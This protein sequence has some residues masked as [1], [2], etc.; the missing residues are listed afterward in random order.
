MDQCIY[1]LIYMQIRD[2]PGRL[3]TRIDAVSCGTRSW[4]PMC[5]KGI[6][7]E[8][9]GFEPAIPLR[10]CRIS[11]AVLSTTQPP[12]RCHFIEWFIAFVSRR[13]IV[14]D[15]QGDNRSLGT[16]SCEPIAVWLQI[17]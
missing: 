7:A 9:A 8:R 12:L 16:P 13:R 2:A 1:L 11:S 14:G 4:G 17:R 3:Q 10:V 15:N 6:M 5:T